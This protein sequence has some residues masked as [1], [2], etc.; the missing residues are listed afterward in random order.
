M[1]EASLYGPNN[2]FITLT[3]DDAHLPHRAMLK[4]EDYQR[5]MK[6]LRK[7]AFPFKL[8]FYMCG[9]YGERSW[10]PHYHALIF[11]YAFFGDRKFA[12]TSPS[13]QKL[14]TSKQLD[15]IWGMGNCWIGSVTFQS[16]AYIARYCTKKV[17]GKA[18]E[19]HYMRADADGVYSLPPE[20][21]KMSL[22]PGIGFTW[23]QQYRKSLY[24][25]D[26]VVSEGKKLKIPRYYDK[27]YQKDM[28]G[29]SVFD[30]IRY[31]RRVMMRE[32]FADNI[33]PRLLVKEEVAEARYQSLVRSFDDGDD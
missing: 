30:D 19:A 12:K 20:F 29:S 3:Y 9:E 26:Y 15:D 11:N 2:S 7:E 1:H 4:Y 16:A 13:G 18:A 21:N 14:Y 6:R 17:T 28:E 33:K 5:F 32:N 31:Q 22:K 8:R 24:P 10:R 25:H 27:L 23:Y